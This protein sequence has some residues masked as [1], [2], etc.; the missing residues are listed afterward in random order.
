MTKE[1]T[2]YWG[3]ERRVWHMFFG[4]VQ[5]LSLSHQSREARD[6]FGRIPFHW[7]IPWNMLS[8]SPGGGVFYT[9]GERSILCSC[10]H[11]CGTV[12]ASEIWDTFQRVWEMFKGLGETL[13]QHEVLSLQMW[14]EIWILTNHACSY[15]KVSEDWEI[16]IR[17]KE[18]GDLRWQKVSTNLIMLYMRW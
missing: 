3:N 7:R 6:W 9:I 16:W 5:G 12:R 2:W 15:P 8:V 4:P 11:P 17:D 14:I 13:N 18:V 10:A 1:S